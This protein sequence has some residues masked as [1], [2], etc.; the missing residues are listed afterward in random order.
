MRHAW[1]YL[2]VA[3]FLVAGCST[4]TRESQATQTALLE[5]VRS[6]WIVYHQKTI[7]QIRSDKRAL[8]D[9]AFQ[10]DLR[11]AAD[12][13]GKVPVET[14]N[15][16]IAKRE[17]KMAEVEQGLA[18]LNQDFAERLRLIDR[19]LRLGRTTAETLSAW[20]QVQM[21]LRNEASEPVLLPVLFGGTPP[22][23]EEGE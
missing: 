14:V 8:L 2:S 6:E 1:W 4:A 23:N 16:L 7:Q 21:L 13:E 11:A 3:I 15:Q 10:V 5:Q 20:A 19:G 9:L 18:A 22:A 17:Q 12:P